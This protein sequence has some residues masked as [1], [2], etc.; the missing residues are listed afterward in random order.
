MADQYNA[1]GENIYPVE[2]EDRLLRHE[3]V[4]DVSI[5]GIQDDRFGEVVGAFL[6]IDPKAAERPSD[7]NIRTWVEQVL[8]RHK[9]P[10]HV[11]WLGD[12]DT[13]SDFPKTGSGKHQKHIL[14]AV[15]A[16]IVKG[17]R[18]GKAKL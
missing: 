5:V 2:I 7:R 1:G 3:C 6:Q 14:S 13:P 16:E 17:R 18:T 8:G 4:R 9:A 12:A 15:G 11:F 10:H